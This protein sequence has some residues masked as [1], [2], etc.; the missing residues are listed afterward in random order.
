VVACGDYSPNTVTQVDDSM[1]L[2]VP[3]A[4]EQ[5]RMVNLNQL[6]VEASIGGMPINMVRGSD[7]RWSGR[8][9]LPGPGTHNLQVRWTEVINGNNLI[10][11][12]ID[13]LPINDNSN[14]EIR[15]LVYRF[16]F[17]FDSDTTTNIDERRDPE[18]NPFVADGTGGP[19][20]NPPFNNMQTACNTASYGRDATGDLTLPDF[21]FISTPLEI[22]PGFVQQ[23]DNT[24]VADSTA[25]FDTLSILTP[26][27]LVI[28]H[29]GGTPDDSVISLHER[30]SDG[31]LSEVGSDDDSGP[32]TFARME[33]PIQTPGGYCFLLRAFARTA[34]GGLSAFGNDTN[35]SPN[36]VLVI[37]FN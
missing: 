22:S 16:N 28:E 13:P 24:D 32:G 20:T 10:L 7:N 23:F 5:A 35:G 31:T 3:R 21:N 18:R 19:F 6:V 30:L 27:T 36:N 29:T 11:A 37:T 25:L 34:E 33:V 26:G 17:D 8:F 12:E 2:S 14:R 4:I 15:N 1:N 9:A